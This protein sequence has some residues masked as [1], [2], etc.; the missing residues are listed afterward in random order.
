MFSFLQKV[1]GRDTE[2]P[3]VESDM[4]RESEEALHGESEPMEP[5]DD[6]MQL[7][8]RDMAGSEGDFSVAEYETLIAKA[9][10]ELKNAVGEPAKATA[11]RKVGDLN[12][13]RATAAQ[14]EQLQERMREQK[15]R[16]PGA[17]P[18]RVSPKP[19]APLA[20]E[21]GSGAGG[22]VPEAEGEEPEEQEEV[23][24]PVPAPSAPAP[25]APAA[26]PARAPGAEL[27]LKHASSAPEPLVP[28]V[29]L[30][31]SRPPLPPAPAAR[32]VSAPFRVT[33]GDPAA[34]GAGGGGAGAPRRSALAEALEKALASAYNPASSAAVAATSG[35]RST[36]N[37]VE[38]LLRD[39]AHG[40]DSA[41][42]DAKGTS[43]HSFSD[44]KIPSH[45]RLK[46]DLSNFDQSHSLYLGKTLKSALNRAVLAWERNP[47][48]HKHAMTELIF[49]DVSP[50][51]Q[52][53]VRNTASRTFSELVHC[54][55]LVEPSAHQYKSHL[56][57]NSARL[58]RMIQNLA[59][60]CGCG[61]RS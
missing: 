44:Y 15:S 27:D 19:P 53:A 35:S 28:S 33:P 39:F 52:T 7:D 42:S 34:A 56:A 14:R 40:A 57:Y 23:R 55:C 41:N 13:K 16:A 59:K 10:K 24:E 31:D 47:S 37:W 3:P 20:P 38:T 49:G 17:S 26:V 5:V 32:L 58:A 25:A 60:S 1:L 11:R 54:F 9:E 46:T 43:S 61:Y 2:A 30:P 21:E 45:L 50:E 18:V 48:L 29:A 8:A 6:D 12:T 4:D 51:L 22:A 36:L